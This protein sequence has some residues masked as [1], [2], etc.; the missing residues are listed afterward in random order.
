MFINIR[1][2]LCS[3]HFEFPT[4]SLVDFYVL[5]DSVIMKK[6]DYQP[7]HAGGSFL[8]GQEQDGK[9]IFHEGGFDPIL[10]KLQGFS[11]LLTQVE[12]WN[13]I[14]SESE[15]KKLAKC[16][17]S[18]LRPQNRV[19]TWGSR[20]WDA[21][22]ANFKDVPLEKMCEQNLVLNQLIWPRSITFH[23]FNSYC[24]AFNGKLLIDMN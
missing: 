24:S 4:K 7:L 17:I 16:E 13:T 15:V 6:E 18:T 22:N 8:L 10:D 3:V 23:K 1:D 19:V 20:T 9:A 21:Q 14:L 2:I 12:L 11:G 5:S